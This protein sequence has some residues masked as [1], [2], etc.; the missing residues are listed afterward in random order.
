MDMMSA[1]ARFGGD[2]GIAKSFEAYRD[3]KDFR[4]FLFTKEGKEMKRA[5]DETIKSIMA[6]LGV[7]GYYLISYP[8]KNYYDIIDKDLPVMK[9]I[10]LLHRS[11]YA[12]EKWFTPEGTPSPSIKRAQ[13]EKEANE[14]I[15]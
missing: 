10:N 7:P 13:T 15:S 12:D 5:L 14:R 11:W 2:K 9:R 4:S 1:S 3:S 8:V 6:G